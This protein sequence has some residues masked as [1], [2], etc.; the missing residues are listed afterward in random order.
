MCGALSDERTGLW[1]TLSLPGNEFRFLGP[2]SYTFVLVAVNARLC[3]FLDV[4]P[5]TVHVISST[6]PYWPSQKYFK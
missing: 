3:T 5:R 2:L 6:A 1:F 4:T